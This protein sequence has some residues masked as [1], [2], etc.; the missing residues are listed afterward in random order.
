MHREEQ[1]GWK[2]PTNRRKSHI[3]RH[4][5]GHEIAGEDE[6]GVKLWGNRR[7]VSD[8][9]ESRTIGSGSR[10]RSLISGLELAHV[11]AGGRFIAAAPASCMHLT[12]N[13]L[14]SATTT[15]YRESLHVCSN[16]HAAATPDEIA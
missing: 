4:E 12:C 15:M 10:S 11:A 3:G 16:E 1:R 7:T 13:A 2:G 8:V 9:R 6:Q 5:G 14:A